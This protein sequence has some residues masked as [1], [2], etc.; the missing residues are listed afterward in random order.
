MYGNFQCCGES[1]GNKISTN[2]FLER[3]WSL[4][5]HIQSLWIHPKDFSGEWGPDIKDLK[6]K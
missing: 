6:F 5:F 2:Y 3:K 1:L 4:K